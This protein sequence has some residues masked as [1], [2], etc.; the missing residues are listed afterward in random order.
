MSGL[1]R[2]LTRYTILSE[3]P[4]SVPK[5]HTKELNYHQID[6]LLQPSWAPDFMGTHIFLN[7]IYMQLHLLENWQDRKF[8][9]CSESE[10]NMGKAH[11]SQL[12]TSQF[13]LRS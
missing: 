10:H 11:L 8:L 1:E 5:I 3:D 4:N 6:A 7:D 13:Q 9:Q 12:W 2:W